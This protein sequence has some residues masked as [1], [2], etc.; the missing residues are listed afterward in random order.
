MVSTLLLKIL[1]ENKPCPN[2][3]IYI[4]SWSQFSGGSESGIHVFWLCHIRV[5][6]TKP[7]ANPIIHPP[8]SWQLI[9]FKKAVI[10][11]LFTDTDYVYTYMNEILYEYMPINT[12][13]KRNQ[14]ESHRQGTWIRWMI[15][16]EGNSSRK[17]SINSPKKAQ[18]RGRE[19]GRG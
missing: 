12:P 7:G 10:I 4:S 9:L 13:K 14:G 3:M 5:E 19:T 18:M 2:R 17:V 8:A 11:S 1:S 16:W 6:Q 15:V